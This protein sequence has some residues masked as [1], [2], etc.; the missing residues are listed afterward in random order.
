MEGEAT[1]F[2]ASK[3]YLS[4]TGNKVFMVVMS[5]GYALANLYEYSPSATRQHDRL[6]RVLLRLFC[7][8]LQLPFLGLLRHRCR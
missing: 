4:C 1:S 7:L 5:K 6:R 2:T 8:L 3:N